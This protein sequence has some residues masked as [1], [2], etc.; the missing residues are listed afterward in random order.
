MRSLPM[1][2]I[3]LGAKCPEPAPEAPGP[4][5]VDDPPGDPPPN[6]D[7]LGPIDWEPFLDASFQG[8]LT[9]ISG[10]TAGATD[11][12]ITSVNALFFTY[13]VGE[14]CTHADLNGYCFDRSCTLT[15]PPSPITTFGAGVVDIVGLR[16]PVQLVEEINYDGLYTFF[17]SGTPSYYLPGA[18][19]T[20]T[21]SGDEV[22]AFVLTTPAPDQNLTLTE[23]PPPSG[24]APVTVS[25]DADL[26]YTWVPSA[27]GNVVVALRALIGPYDTRLIQCSQFADAGELVVP[28][29]DIADFDAPAALE[30]IRYTSTEFISVGD[31]VVMLELGSP[32]VGPDGTAFPIRTLIFE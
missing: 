14:T 17:E 2:L 16:E 9:V 32:V 28:L 25:P 23:P 20:A 10:A 5:G 7:S 29:S 6:G 13:E 26:F 30:S 8:A 21:A 27:N 19:V 4:G 24:Y 11:S 1:C 18:D 15:I 3:L 12:T 22:P 31:F